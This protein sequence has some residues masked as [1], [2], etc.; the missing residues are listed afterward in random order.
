MQACRVAIADENE[1]TGAGFQH[2]GK[3]LA[4]HHRR[5]RGVDLVGT[6][7]FFGD[8]RGKCGFA[9]VVRQH[10]I[11]GPQIKPHLGTMEVRSTFDHLAD[12]L[13]QEFAHMRREGAV[14]A[15]Q[16]RGLRNHVVG[17]AGL[18]GA[19]RNHCRIER[20]DVARDDRLQLIDDLAAHK[21]RIDCDVGPC[22]VAADA[23]DFDRDV[24][25]RRHDRSRADREGAR[26]H[27]GKLCMP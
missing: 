19:D 27:P 25:G 16:H 11:A 17:I 6:G 10:R 3:V 12:P 4:T 18:E 13:A 2:I 7:N 9:L 23:L 22:C 26:R 1:S 24:V 20:I 21:D 8:R 14:G 15:A 5:H